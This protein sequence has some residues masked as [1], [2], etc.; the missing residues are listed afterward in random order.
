[1]SWCGHVR[2]TRSDAHGHR[3]DHRN[4]VPSESLQHDRDDG[5]QHPWSLHRVR[6]L[7][8]ETSEEHIADP[9]VVP[10]CMRPEHLLHTRR[11]A[12]LHLS[13]GVCHRGISRD[14]HDP[15]KKKVFRNET[16]SLVR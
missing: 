4:R 16:T 6:A 14:S 9:V 1:M 11:L 3:G 5:A 2:S 15:L 13:H 10:R 12:L 8:S 7:S